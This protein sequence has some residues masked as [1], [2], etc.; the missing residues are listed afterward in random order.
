MEV[1]T[2]MNEY[3]FLLLKIL[4]QLL[5]SRIYLFNVH[6]IFYRFNSVNFPGY[7]NCLVLCIH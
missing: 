1:F 4:F 7:F 6:I 2:G 5:R 3:Q